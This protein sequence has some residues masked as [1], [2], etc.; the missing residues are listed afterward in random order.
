M[1]LAFSC[2]LLR[3]IN[4]CFISRII[5]QSALCDIFNMASLPNINWHGILLSVVCVSNR[6]MDSLKYNICLR[7]YELWLVLF[8]VIIIFFSIVAN[9]IMNSLFLSNILDVCHGYLVNH[10]FFFDCI[11]YVVGSLGIS[12]IFESSSSYLLFI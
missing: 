12:F 2:N 6:L 8:H 9:F 7:I 4:F 3:F 5:F 11:R 1:H 10:G